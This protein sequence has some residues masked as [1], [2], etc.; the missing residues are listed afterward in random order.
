MLDVLTGG[1]DPDGS[2]GPMPIVPTVGGRVELLFGQKHSERFRWGQGHFSL[3]RD[4]LRKQFAGL[5]QQSPR[6]ARKCLDYWC[7]KYGVG[8]W[9]DLVPPAL[10]ADV[11]GRLP[12]ETTINENFTRADS[13]SAIGNHLSWTQ[14]SGTWGT[15]SN[16]AY[17]VST[18]SVIESARAD[19]DLSSSDHYAQV[20]VANGNG[21]VFHGPACRHSS[22]ASTYYV[23]ANFSNAQY[24]TKLIAGTQTNLT[25]TAHNYANGE[26]LKI[27]ANGSSI[28]GYANGT[29]YPST[30]DTSITSGTRCGIVSS[31]TNGTFDDFEAADLAAAGLVYT[32]L[33]RGVRGLLRGLWT[34]RG[35]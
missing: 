2:D 26:T 10:R 5:W 14:V 19:S 27:E 32:Q 31:L 21:S 35:V 18:A 9:A 25:S 29:Q 17:K 24:L 8:D 13:A 15:F 22:S 20:V 7:E 4:G 3:V 16:T 28:K 1:A 11:P 34:G 33:E 30:T 12:H 23:T 6:L